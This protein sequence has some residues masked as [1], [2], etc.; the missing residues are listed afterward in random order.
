MNNAGRTLTFGNQADSDVRIEA[1]ESQPV[2]LLTPA[3]SFEPQLSLPGRHN[4]HNA[5]AATAVALALGIDIQKIRQGLE[6]VKPVPGRLNLIRTEA[7]WT[8]IDD[9]YNANPASFVFGAAGAC[10]H[11]GGTVAG[12]GRHERTG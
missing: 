10:G 6:A 7:G 1:K 4:L 9:T 5:A 3:G 8:V 2:H 11:A 12:T